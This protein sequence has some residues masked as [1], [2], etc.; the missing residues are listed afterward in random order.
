M[1]WCVEDDDSISD[2]EVYALNS[3]GFNAKN[4]NDGLLFWE[5]LNT[6]EP[7]E[8]VILDIMLPGIDGVELLSRMKK[9]TL[10]SK[11]PVIMATAKGGEYDKIK[12]L[13]IGADDYLVKPFSI[14]EMISRVKA[15]LRRCKPEDKKEI[16]KIF[17]IVLN[18]NEHKVIVDNEQ[19]MLTYKEFKLLQLFLANPGRAF[20][21]EHLFNEVWGSDYLGDTRTL[22]MH[23]R[24]LRQKLKN[25]GNIIKTVRGVGYRLETDI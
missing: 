14:M 22:D 4:Y 11:I 6:E 17:G 1:I 12:S 23:I 2:I 24:T 21:R 15:V 19:I 18:M 5:A 3:A 16:L 13:D 10:F 8:L 20:T 7:P 9:S 25:Y